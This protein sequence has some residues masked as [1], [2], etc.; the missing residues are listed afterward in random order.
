MASSASLAS[1]LRAEESST[2]VS[3]RSRTPERDA[4]PTKIESRS[5]K[6][7]SP[8]P[9]LQ[10]LKRK[11]SEA[12]DLDDISVLDVTPPSKKAILSVA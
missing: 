5:P 1:K 6:R 2:S 8:E 9:M 4:T 10:G 3:S 12:S 7:E 11:A